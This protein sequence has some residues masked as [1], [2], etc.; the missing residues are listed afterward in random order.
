MCFCQILMVKFLKIE[1]A[2]SQIDEKNGN[3]AVRNHTRNRK[4]ELPLHG[5]SGWLITCMT[6]D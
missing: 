6:K 4:I 5:H 2:S 3:F 1:I